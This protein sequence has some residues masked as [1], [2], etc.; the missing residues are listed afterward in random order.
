MN[1]IKKTIKVLLVSPYSAKKVGGIG[2]WSKSVIDCFNENQ[3]IK[4]LFQNT[5]FFLKHDAKQKQSRVRRL[6]IGAI[7]TIVILTKLFFN[8]LFKRPSVIHYTSS[9]SWA[10]SKDRIANMIS[11]LFKIPF[12]IHWHFGRIPDIILER[13]K[14]YSKLKKVIKSCTCSIVNE[15]IPA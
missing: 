10:L 14:E 2:T 15:E 7:D 1:E 8:C 3:I 13:G 9:A 4:I 5:A 11:K 12:I 6:I